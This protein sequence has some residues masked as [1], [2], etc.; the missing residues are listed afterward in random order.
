MPRKPSAIFSINPK[1]ISGIASTSQLVFSILAICISM[2]LSL[3]AGTETASTDPQLQ[4][5]ADQSSVILSAG[6]QA[7]VRL[8]IIP[9]GSVSLP[10]TFS[11]EGLPPGAGCTFS[12]VTSLPAEIL[13]TLDTTV[14]NTGLRRGAFP[15]A[16]S[17][18]TGTTDQDWR[19][20]YYSPWRC[21]GS[22][23]CLS[24]KK[25]AL[26]P[27]DT[28]TAHLRNHSSTDALGAQS[29]G[30]CFFWLL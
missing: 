20:S 29:L 1:I 11:C 10:I 6:Q 25:T 23:Y 4:L 30:F 13:M 27:G 17:L 7:I 3:H 22:C 12:P 19:R 14:S 28:P 8:A 16:E 26:T 2:T 24:G 15:E 21:R 5:L 9:T 18:L